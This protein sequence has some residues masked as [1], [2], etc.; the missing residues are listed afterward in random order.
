MKAF[1]IIL[2][3][4]FGFIAY[5]IIGIIGKIGNKVETGIDYVTGTGDSEAEQ[6]NAI[7][8]A[9]NEALKYFNPAYGF[10]KVRLKY[11]DVNSYYLKVK[12]FSSNEAD[13]LAKNIYDAKGFINDNELQVYNAF[14]QIPSLSCLSLVAHRFI[15]NYPL[16]GGLLQYI[17]SFLSTKELSTVI[18]IISKKPVY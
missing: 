17:S 16:K 10:N 5:K 18:R 11:P 9:T 2:T 14:N 6:Q 7:Q 12:N 8:Q 15:I 4:I 1:D 3:I 13:V